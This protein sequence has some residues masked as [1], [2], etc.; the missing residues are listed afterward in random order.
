MNAAFSSNDWREQ[1]IRDWLLLMLRFAVIRD[2]SDQSAVFAMADELDALGVRWRP[3]APRFFVTT[4]GEV[5]DAILGVGENA[6]A[7]LRT[8]IARID[9]PR[10]RGA[11]AAAVYLQQ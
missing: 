9:D 3:P 11:F 1:K 8:H 6:N 7:V 10:I 4:A 2:P 5:C